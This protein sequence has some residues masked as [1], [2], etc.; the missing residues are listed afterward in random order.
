MD[1]MSADFDGFHVNILSLRGA[2]VAAKQSP[3]ELGIASVAPLLRNDETAS[4]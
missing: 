2:F 3:I 1:G 4:S